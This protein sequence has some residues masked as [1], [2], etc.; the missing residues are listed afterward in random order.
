MSGVTRL[1][2]YLTRQAERRPEAVALV[3]GGER[4]SYGE[5]ERRSNQIARLLR[6]SGVRP[7]D[8]VALL[9]PKTLPTLAAMLGIYKSD[10]VVVPLD[11]ASPAARLQ[12]ILR[13]CDSRLILAGG[14]LGGRTTGAD[15]VAALVREGALPA[16][17]RLG[18]LG[19]RSA[20]A[21]GTDLAP[22]FEW[23]D[24]L[25]ASGEPVAPRQ[26]ADDAAHILY[27]SGSTG[28]PKGVVVR[29][30]S[31]VHFVDWA[32]E[33][34]GMREDDRVSAHSPLPF[35][36]STFDIFGALAAGAEL[37]L[38]PPELNLLPHRLVEW[39][40]AERLTQW[41]SVP[42]LLTYMV[43]FDVLRHGDF[44]ELRR[45]LWCGEVFPTAALIHWMERLPHVAFTNLYGPTEATI[46][47]TWYDMPRAPSDPSA[48]VPIGRAIPGEELFVLDDDLAPLP[49][50]VA[51]GLYIRGAGLSPGYWRDPER[52][53]AAF[54]PN[55]FGPA[56]GDRLYR[57][58][59]LAY[60]GADGM[61]Y[62]LGRADSQIK[63]RGYRI[64][65]GEIESAVLASG[66]VREAVVTAVASGDFEGTVICC[67]YVADRPE[68][69]HLELKRRLGELLPPY[70]MPARFAAAATLPR[71]G[72]GKL[73]RRA[74][75]EDFARQLAPAPEKRAAVPAPLLGD[76]PGAPA[77]ESR[78]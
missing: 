24:V 53:R 26:R 64:E 31:V 73:D 75:Q 19:D 27:T 52:T 47:S 23:R 78:R 6:A 72:N 2:Q 58:G 10:A 11:E 15:R 40:R 8:R 20:L 71:N 7:G 76:G 54:V 45:L 61:L 42:S 35:D 43:K 68:T 33:H 29:H 74:V 67:A 62:L 46:A 55:P 65:L 77:A 36:L 41:F 56:A 3:A 50:G 57:T 59:D 22:A 63:C 21:D 69:T 70:M 25:G 38:V 14:G 28:E 4:M 49:A 48:P 16:D 30:A 1:P 12:R 5:L 13:S 34:F 44:P 37:H 32:V 17:T 9:A 66:L 18:L 39:M 60:T 51:G